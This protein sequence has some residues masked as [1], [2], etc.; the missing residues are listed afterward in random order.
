MRAS[1]IAPTEGNTRVILSPS[2]DG[3][4][5]GLRAPGHDRGVTRHLAAR[6]ILRQAQDDVHD[7]DAIYDAVVR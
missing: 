6:P 1:G 5:K 3:P 4:A 7:M 2:K